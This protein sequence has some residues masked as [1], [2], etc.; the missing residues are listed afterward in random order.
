MSK[1]TYLG[2]D[3]VYHYDPYGD[4]TFCHRVGGTWR[5][6]PYWYSAN[7]PKSKNKK[8]KTAKR[9]HRHT[10]EMPTRRLV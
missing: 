9:K 3:G 4:N 1:K 10:K 2:S 8:R 6:S 7:K 5:L